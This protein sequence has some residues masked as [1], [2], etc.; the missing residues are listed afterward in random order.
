MYTTLGAA[1]MS[2]NVSAGSLRPAAVA[3]G[4]GADVSWY[5]TRHWGLGAGVEAAFPNLQ[6]SSAGITPSLNAASSLHTYT[7]RIDATSLRIPLLLC[8]R[9]PVWRQWFYVA[10]GASLD[11]ALTGRYRTET[12][13]RTGNSIQTE[14]T[15]GMLSLG[16]GVSLAAEAGFRWTLDSEWGIY[17][18]AYAAY[19]LSDICPSG[20]D[21]L[22][23]V[24]R[25]N[26]LLVGLKVK[27]TLHQ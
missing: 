16:H 23:D 27:I 19:G 9:A 7:T 12:T 8:F 24:T 2:G 17:T 10:A 1:A 13:V 26:L 4:V 14:V 6:L 21:A 20:I 5:F 18:G 11:L 25:L 22:S 15:T 3:A